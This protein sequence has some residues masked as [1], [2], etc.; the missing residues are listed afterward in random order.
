MNTLAFANRCNF[1]S[2]QLTD[3]VF[4]GF[5]QQ[6]CY[7]WHKSDLFL[8]RVNFW[9]YVGC[10]HRPSS[11][12]SGPQSAEWLAQP[13]RA[14]RVCTLPLLL[15]SPLL[16]QHHSPFHSSMDTKTLSIHASAPGQEKLHSF[17]GIP[18]HW[19]RSS[20]IAPHSTALSHWIDGASRA[21]S[22][23]TVQLNIFLPL[24]TSCK[25][26]QT[27]K[28]FVF[29]FKDKQFTAKDEKAKGMFGIY[30]FHLWRHFN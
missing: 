21:T 11:P 16:S 20:V 24:E 15:T 1:I 5:H 22:K 23:F 10:A 6:C 8:H 25:S 12:A 19:S 18:M 28:I 26:G 13:Q 9:W 27:V 30:F 7:P 14:S 2:W 3:V 17:T 29:L 4:V